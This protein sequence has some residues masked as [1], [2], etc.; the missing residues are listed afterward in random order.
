MLVPNL[1]NLRKGRKKKTKPRTEVGTG[2]INVSL[3]QYPEI[4]REGNHRL[5]N[6][7]TA[8]RWNED[9]E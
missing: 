7:M 6:G 2:N 9:T 5:G 4:F 8:G 3:H 1:S